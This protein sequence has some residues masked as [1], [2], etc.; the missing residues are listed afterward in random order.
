MA[1]KNLAGHHIQSAAFEATVTH[2]AFHKSAVLLL[3]VEA[4]QQKFH[5]SISQL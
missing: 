4:V 1:V 3:T 5:L 2:S